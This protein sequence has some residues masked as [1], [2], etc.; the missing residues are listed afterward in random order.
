M[1]ATIEDR[2]TSTDWKHVEDGS[3]PPETENSKDCNGCYW[4][5][6][7]PCRK[8][9]YGVCG[10]KESVFHGDYTSATRTCTSWEE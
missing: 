10:N 7:C 1:R 5:N 6:P 8:C 9:E 3:E 4:W 2:N